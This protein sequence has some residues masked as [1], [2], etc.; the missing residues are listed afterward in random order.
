M[1]LFIWLSS[2]Q[3]HEDGMPYAINKQ[4]DW[5]FGQIYFKYDYANNN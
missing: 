3:D 4:Q 5:T 1:I 2:E